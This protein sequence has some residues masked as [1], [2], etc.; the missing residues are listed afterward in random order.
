MQKR[1]ETTQLHMAAGESYIRKNISLVS[2][3]IFFS[4]RTP[5]PPPSFEK[6]TK[7]KVYSIL[8]KA[9]YVMEDPSYTMI[10][11]HR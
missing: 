2:K 7:P 10:K 1:M 11:S 4:T 9:R 8:E 6:S 3:C 5:P